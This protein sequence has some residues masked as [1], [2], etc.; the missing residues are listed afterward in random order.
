[1]KTNTFY[2]YST[3]THNQNISSIL[4]LI[5]L[6]TTIIFIFLPSMFTSLIKTFSLSF[7]P[8]PNPVAPTSSLLP[9]HPSTIPDNILIIQLNHQP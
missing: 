9:Y 7:H 1:M 4:L 3:Q 8:N 6:S 2:P 5:F